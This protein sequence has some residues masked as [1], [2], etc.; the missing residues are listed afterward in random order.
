MKGSCCKES[1]GA[2]A[3]QDACCQSGSQADQKQTD[4][5]SSCCKDESS[6]KSAQKKDSCCGQGCS[7]GASSEH[8]VVYEDASEE[9]VAGQSGSCC[10][11]DVVEDPL[12]LQIQE[13][14]NTLKHVQADFENYRKRTEK[15]NQE[16]QKF[17]NQQLFAQLL[18]LIE[19]FDF[20]LRNTKNQEQ[21]V[22]GVQM[23]REQF[24]HFLQQQGLQP[25][26]VKEHE[27]FNP[28]S[29]EAVAVEEAKDKHGKPLAKNTI[30]T[31]LA[32]GYT[33]HGKVVRPV[34][35]KVAK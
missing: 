24:K 16:F 10:R 34:K 12:A 30:I 18:P 20:A 8:D 22:Q 13:L 29:H 1:K 33:L 9:E 6:N 7:E 11:E 14:T 26:A 27:L 2:S 23:I 28:H 4:Q 5:K 17:A 15:L 31:V 32:E 25:I 3:P 21:F 19:Q 35:V